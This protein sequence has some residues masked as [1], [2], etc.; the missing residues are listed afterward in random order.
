MKKKQNS[1]FSFRLSKIG[2]DFIISESNQK[3]PKET[4][5][6]L[7]GNFDGKCFY[8]EK[9]IGPGL[10]AEH[11]LFGFKRNGNFAQAQMDSCIKESSG[12]VDY[13]G[14]WHSHP[15][16][17]GP[18][19]T[20]YNSIRWVANNPKYFIS[21]PILGICQKNGSSWV[22]RVFICSGKDLAEV[23]PANGI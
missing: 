22:F 7:L 18:S 16:N 19:K 1:P 9:A 3:F 4:G 14:E 10:D 12:L 20:D 11:S 8:I 6:I 2:L 5:G 15:E 17:I 23:L 21:I 13:I